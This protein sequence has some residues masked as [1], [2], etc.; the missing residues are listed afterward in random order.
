MQRKKEKKRL[1]K[2]NAVVKDSS[3]V[4][5]F[6]FLLRIHASVSVDGKSRQKGIF[7]SAPIEMP[8]LLFQDE[9]QGKSDFSE[10]EDEDDTIIE[11]NA[12]TTE[13]SPSDKTQ[14]AIE[15]AGC[16]ESSANS[17]EKSLV[18]MNE[19]NE[20]EIQKVCQ[21]FTFLLCETKRHLFSFD[22]LRNQVPVVF[23]IFYYMQSRN[24][25]FHAYFKKMTSSSQKHLAD[26]YPHLVSSSAGFEFK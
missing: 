7:K 15:A 23:T 22:G 17:E 11:S 5:P 6:L 3:P 19:K 12:E 1:E 4:S 2:E 10:K 24:A 20:E 13:S 26:D 8:F 18:K 25:I 16:D 14:K 9:E 21:S